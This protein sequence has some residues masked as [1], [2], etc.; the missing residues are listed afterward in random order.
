[1]TFGLCLSSTFW[2]NK[3]AGE[4][5]HVHADC[6]L[7]VPGLLLLP[8]DNSANHHQPFALVDNKYY[9]QLLA[10]V[11]TL[12]HRESLLHEPTIT[13]H[14]SPTAVRRQLLPPSL[15]TTSSGPLTIN[16][17]PP[18]VPDCSLHAQARPRHPSGPTIRNREELSN[19]STAATRSWRGRLGWDD[20]GLGAT[21]K[22]HDTGHR[23]VARWTRL[24][25]IVN[26]TTAPTGGLAID[27]LPPPPVL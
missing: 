1:M 9:I 5:S 17:T 11:Q 6:T 4:S 21:P 19:I 15:V 10:A 13:L 7:V 24:V 20:C 25:V 16:P 18:R 27:P 22:F 12:C 26:N 2:K 8:G 23:G 14:L 3:L